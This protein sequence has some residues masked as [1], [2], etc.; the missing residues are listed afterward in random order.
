M[1]TKST[2][3]MTCML[4]AC[5]MTYGMRNAYAEE[6]K[7]KPVRI[8][9]ESIEG[10]IQYR[11]L[12]RDASETIRIDQ[13]VDTT[14]IDFVLP[15]GKYMIRIGA[16]NKF[17]KISFWTDWEDIEIRKS[18]KSNFFTNEYAAKVGLKISAGMIYNMIL[19]PW[20]GLYKNSGLNYPYMNFTGSIGF[21]F[22]NSKY[23]KPENFLKYLGIELEGAYCRFEG[24]KTYQFESTLMNITA[25]PNLFIKTN[26]NIPLNFYARVGGGASYSLQDY[27][28]RTL[29]GLPI[30]RGTIKT[31]DPYAKAGVSMEI[32]LL[33]A[34]S[35][36][37]GADYI[38]IFYQDK[39]FHGL[40]FIARIGVRI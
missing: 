24:K 1:H 30:L 7:E 32:N 31:L 28:R 10:I 12:I 21:H 14:Y 33:Y 34:M 40:R 17:E 25:G 39:I 38:F 23:F 36:D 27:T 15:P 13:T 2:L 35:L 8:K 37:I 20:S 18:I 29:Q 26:L 11:V 22:G 4:A 3:M 5:M 9:W 16:I 19:P 6:K